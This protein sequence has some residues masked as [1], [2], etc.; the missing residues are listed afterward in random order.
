IATVP[1]EMADDKLPCGVVNDD[2]IATLPEL[3]Q[4]LCDKHRL[5]RSSVAHYQKMQA[6][7][8]AAHPNDLLL[9]STG[10]NPYPVSTS[11]L[12]KVS[13]CENLRSADVLASPSADNVRSVQIDAYRYDAH[14][15]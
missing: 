8:L 13:D 11:H 4:E 7:V 12:V 1:V 5:S 6:F 14:E 10:V 15:H 2:R 9:R 3:V